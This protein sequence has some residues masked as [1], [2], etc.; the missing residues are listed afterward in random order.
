MKH[1]PIK[2]PYAMDALE[3]F[4][5]KETLHY[6]Y[7]KHHAGYVNKLNTLIKNTEYDAMSL[8][9]IITQSEGAIFNNAAQ[10]FNHN[11]YWSSLWY[12]KTVPSKALKEKIIE[13]FGDMDKF[14]ETF[15]QSAVDNFGSGWTWLMLDQHEHLRITNTSNADTPIAHHNMPLIACDVWEHA[16][17]LDYKNVRLDY[18]KAFYEHINWD[19]ASKIFDNTEHLNQVGLSS[20][21]NNDPDDGMSDYLDELQQA[22]D[23][24]S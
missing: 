9:S 5:S 22:E 19:N 11:F 21:I 24:S 15:I 6:H 17:Y 3:P 10:A 12:E 1:T 13:V 14:K 4:L 2:L 16:Y 18:L 23:V 7:D 20:I 8:K